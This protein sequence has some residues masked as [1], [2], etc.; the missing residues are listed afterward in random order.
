VSIV[1]VSYEWES[2]FVFIYI[3]VHRNCLPHDVPQELKDWATT[4]LM[5]S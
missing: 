2:L 4:A 1:N 3:Q 5:V